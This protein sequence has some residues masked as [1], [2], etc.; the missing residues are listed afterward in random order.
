[1]I[2]FARLLAEAVNADALRNEAIRDLLPDHEATPSGYRGRSV[3]LDTRTQADG[4]IGVQGL[5]QVAV[6][7]ADAAIAVFEEGAAHRATASTNVNEHSSRSHCVMQVEV[8]V[9]RGQGTAPVR[10]RLFLVDLAG[11]ERVRRSGAQ[12]AV[13]KEAQYVPLDCLSHLYLLPL[14]YSLLSLLSLCP[15]MIII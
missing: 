7:D 6:K 5:R 8:T 14:F 15:L 1:M 2:W 9:A 13:L 10:S 3:S 12:G 4:S 11:C